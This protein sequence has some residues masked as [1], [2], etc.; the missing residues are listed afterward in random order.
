MVSLQTVALRRLHLNC[1]GC[2]GKVALQLTDGTA[3]WRKGGS[4][5]GGGGSRLLDRAAG[6]LV[7]GGG[8]VDA[9]G[10]GRAV[11]RAVVGVAVA[12]VVAAAARPRPRRPLKV[13]HARELGREQLLQLRQHARGSDT[14]RMVQVL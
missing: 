3:Q 2:T 9:L 6:G 8:L 4:V 1:K 14:V 5:D 13:L 10:Q 7:K 12:V 11:E